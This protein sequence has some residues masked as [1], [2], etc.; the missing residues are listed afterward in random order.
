MARLI[1]SDITR[2]SLAGSD[3]PEL[4]TLA[5]LRD[6]LPDDYTIFHGVHWANSSAYGT[7]FGEID[8]VIVNQSGDLLVIEQ[9]NGRVEETSQGLTKSYGN[10][11]KSLDSQIQRNIGNIRTKF[12]ARHGNEQGLRVE[13]LIYCPDYRVLDVN[14]AGIDKERTVDATTRDQ[15]HGRVQD[16]LGPG[17]SND[18]AWAYVV[19]QFFRQSL[20]VVPDVSAYVSSQENIY[21]Q[22]LEGLA[23]VI[24]K[25]EFTPFRLRVIGTAGAGKSQLTLSLCARAVEES[26]RPLL[27]CFNRPFADKMK[28]M[29]PAGVASNTYLGFCTEFAESKGLDIDFSR[30]T[31]DP[32]FW[33]RIQEHAM[34]AEIPDGDRY[35]FL[36]IDEGQDFHQDWFD[37]LRLFL[38]KGASIIWLEDPLQNLRSTKPVDLPGFVTYRETSNYRS[39]G[40]IA[41]FIKHSLSV[42]FEQKNSLP[43]LGVEIHIYDKPHE[44]IKIVTHRITELV[45]AG[46]SHDEIVVISCRGMGSSAFKDCDKLGALPVRRFTGEYD[47][48]GT[49]IYTDGRIYFDTIFR[50]KGQQ[51]SAVILV[52]I[53]ETLVDSE[54]VR[55]ILYCGMT[56]ATV[57]LELVVQEGNPWQKKFSDANA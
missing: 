4:E 54:S 1:P 35:D 57:R 15:L 50:F 36:I 21:T 44:Q 40:S 55:R 37:I 3:N 17:S 10:Q 38:T 43:G 5:Y 20:D 47:T 6:K 19:E 12:S 49:Q 24:G 32:E 9:K 13:Y 22:M 8:F 33:Q 11:K 48:R 28:P 51:A 16:L 23:D 29:L 46:F 18:E 42:E 26:H 34:A 53:D 39:P 45:K 30:M 14:A 2:L 27:L 25:L 52:D 56:R 7:R 31:K 41:Q